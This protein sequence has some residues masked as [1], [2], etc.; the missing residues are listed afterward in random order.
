MKQAGDIVII[1]DNNSTSNL[2]TELNIRAVSAGM[3]ICSFTEATQAIEYIRDILCQQNM[4]NIILL[5]DINMPFMSG[6]DV[7]D[8][9]SALNNCNNKCNIRTYILSSSVYFTDKYKAEQNKLISG[10][11]EKP[12]Q[13]KDILNIMC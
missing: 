13:T 6:W 8:K 10:Y 11:I 12:I 2:L 1:I 4:Y 9:I 3:A 5:L 7:L